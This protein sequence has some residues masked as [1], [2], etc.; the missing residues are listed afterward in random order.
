[1]AKQGVISGKGAFL[2]KIH[3]TRDTGKWEKRIRVSE[4][5]ELLSKGT[6]DWESGRVEQGGK[7]GSSAQAKEA[8]RRGRRYEE[9][10]WGVFRKQPG[11]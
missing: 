4:R 5:D 11:Y 10:F 1:M 6:R 8:G 9:H 3:R 2:G 7:R